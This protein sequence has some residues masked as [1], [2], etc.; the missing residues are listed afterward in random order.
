M[1]IYSTEE[2][3]AEAI[4]QFFRDNG[5]SLALGIVLGLGGLYGWKAYNQSQITNAEA[6]S[7]AYS[8]VIEGE[9]ILASTESFI[10]DNGDSNY[11]VLAAFVAAKE[12][13][14][15]QQYSVATE[16]LRFA[17]DT[18]KNSELKATALTRLARIQL[19]ENKLDEALATL[20]TEMPDSFNAQVSEIKGDVYLEKGDKP[21][22]RTHYQA[23][24]DASEG[25]NNTLLQNKLDD[26]AIAQ[27]V[28]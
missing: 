13:I 3:Q 4:K 7:N 6:A 20:N 23:A 16:K 26:L 27:P 21:S 19:A 8:K 9:D 25:A 15:K 22:A 10:T 1:E 18:V 5:V 17:A 12:A 2:Q 14:D 24:V 11:A 28:L